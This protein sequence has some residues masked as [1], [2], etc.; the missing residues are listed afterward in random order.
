MSDF[1]PTHTWRLNDYRGDH[2][3]RTPVEVIA[4]LQGLTRVRTSTG[5]QHLAHTDE[6]DPIEVTS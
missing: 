3:T 5:A 4:T 6:L 1:T 2:D